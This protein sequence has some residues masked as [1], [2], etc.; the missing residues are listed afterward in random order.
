MTRTARWGPSLQTVH[1][2]CSSISNSSFQDSPPEAAVLDPAAQ[3]AHPVRKRKAAEAARGVVAHFARNGSDDEGAQ[4]KPRHHQHQKSLLVHVPAGPGAEEGSPVLMPPPSTA[5]KRKPLHPVQ[6]AREECATPATAVKRASPA[7][8]ASAA[9]VTPAVLLVSP[10][11]AQDSTP[12]PAPKAPVTAPAPAAA[13]GPSGRTAPSAAPPAVRTASAFRSV[14]QQEQQEP[15]QQRQQRPGPSRPASHALYPPAPLVSY[16]ALPP[17]RQPPL[18]PALRVPEQPP[19]LFKDTP[20]KALTISSGP[21]TAVTQGYPYLTV[22]QQAAS[23]AQ[24]SAAVY[25]SL[26]AL[27]GMDNRSGF[28]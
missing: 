18:P 5:S 19:K 8:P 16:T 4:K 11:A 23:W 27:R 13:A 6:A 15:Q 22:Q 10:E 1:G 26:Q 12:R 28:K 17:L 14:R 24:F 2:V 7:A 20:A 25:S 9:A 3:A 21:Y